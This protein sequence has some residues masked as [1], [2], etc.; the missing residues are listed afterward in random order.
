MLR[1]DFF[2]P[3][4]PDAVGR[5]SADLGIN[6]SV[7]IICV[8]VAINVFRVHTGEKVGNRNLLRA[9]VH[10]VAAGGAG[11]PV[12][13]I[14]DRAG[15]F[16]GF[17]FRLIKRTEIFHKGYVIGYLLGVAHSRKNHKHALAAG[18]ESYRVACVTSAAEFIE[19]NFGFV[20]KSC[21]ITA[22]DRLH[23]DNGLSVSVAN[24]ET[25]ARL[26]GGI[27]EIYIIQL[28]LNHFD[29]RIF[30]KNLLENLGF[31]VERKYRSA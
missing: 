24:F 1:T 20:G 22:L 12:H 6:L 23:Y 13:S 25:L 19:G 4:A 28:N 29:L 27:V 18:C 30:G 9:A 26:N 21:E 16:H 2:A 5:L 3:S 15:F 7:I 31:I 8:S 10:A 17:E 11:D 14:E